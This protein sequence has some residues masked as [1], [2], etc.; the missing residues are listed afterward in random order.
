M[1]AF[2]EQGMKQNQRNPRLPHSI[3][4]VQYLQEVKGDECKDKGQ[5]DRVK[6]QCIDIALAGES[7]IRTQT[8]TKGHNEWGNTGR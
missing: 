2:G 4:T 6:A 8:L 7:V 1:G 3:I 5:A